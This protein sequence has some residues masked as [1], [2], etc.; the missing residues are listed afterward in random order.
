MKLR[1]WI[2]S[3]CIGAFS[4]GGLL[5]TVASGSGDAIQSVHSTT[6]A[7]NHELGSPAVQETPAQTSGFKQMARQEYSHMFG[8]DKSLTFSG[9]GTTRSKTAEL[10]FLSVDSSSLQVQPTSL[11]DFYESP[12]NYG[13]AY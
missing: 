1:T 5:Q 2:S 10:S 8:Q 9:G 3:I 13:S 12:A 11:S 6:T 7:N 4:I